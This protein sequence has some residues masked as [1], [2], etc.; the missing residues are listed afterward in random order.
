MMVDYIMA[1]YGNFWRL[2][3]ERGQKSKGWW[4]MVNWWPVPLIASWSSLEGQPLPTK[5]FSLLSCHSRQLEESTTGLQER[6]MGN[7][8]K[9]NCTGC[10]ET[11]WLFRLFE[12]SKGSARVW[13]KLIRNQV[14]MDHIDMR[15]V[16]LVSQRALLDGYIDEKT[17]KTL[18]SKITLIVIGIGVELVN[19]QVMCYATWYTREYWIYFLKH[20]FQSF[21][22]GNCRLYMIDF[23]SFSCRSPIR[24]YKKQTGTSRALES[25]R[26]VEIVAKAKQRNNSCCPHKSM[27]NHV[28]NSR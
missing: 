18:N 22:E 26:L 27:T 24:K 10:I 28:D 25:P 17:L 16:I 2:L 21:F 7:C 19:S 4:M 1:C 8:E 20:L 14:I 23:E 11:T 9:V 12:R 6:Q 5:M 13:N 15:V 3:V